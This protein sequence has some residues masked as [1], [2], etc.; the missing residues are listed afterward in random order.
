MDKMKF[1]LNKELTYPAEKFRRNDIE[2]PKN[3]IT[4]K[5]TMKFQKTMKVQNTIKQR[6]EVLSMNSKSRTHVKKVSSKSS[7]KKPLTKSKESSLKPPPKKLVFEDTPK[8]FK[9]NL[10]GQL[11][12]VNAQIEKMN[13]SVE[14]PQKQ[15]FLRDFDKEI[16]NERDERIRRS[17]QE[18]KQLNENILGHNIKIVENSLVDDSDILPNHRKGIPSAMRISS[19]M[20]KKDNLRKLTKK[21]ITAR[22]P[23]EILKHTFEQN[24]LK[25]EAQ[26]HTLD[27]QVSYIK[28]V[29]DQNELPLPVFEKLRDHCLKLHGY[30]INSHHMDSLC[31]EIIELEGEVQSII[32]DDIKISQNT[33]IK[34]C[35]TIS[36]NPHITSVIFRNIRSCKISR[37]CIEYLSKVIHPESHQ[38]GKFHR[39]TNLEIHNCLMKPE[40]VEKLTQ[41]LPNNKNLHKLVLTYLPLT[42]GS[43]NNLIQFFSN[44]YNLEDINLSWC[45]IFP[46]SLA[47]V[48]KSLQKIKNLRYLSLNGLNLDIKDYNLVFIESLSHLIVYVFLPIEYIPVSPCCEPYQHK[49][50]FSACSDS[51]HSFF[52]EADFDSYDLEDHCY[53]LPGA[54]PK[55]LEFRL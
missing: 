14:I 19:E 44:N 47:L 45:K 37:K 5:R 42:E 49:S 48:V 39:L 33:L 26:L 12:I 17:N 29:R 6:S 54:V 10:K 53:V 27:N 55:D 30:S 1:R 40:V 16:H 32:L 8:K 7:L 35:K 3:K 25:N 23:G 21:I 34:M 50:C 31:K 24:F 46:K 22:D 38:A 51:Q 2:V 20:Q 36:S 28:M 18:F 15:K 11:K 43:A 41:I 13:N 4:L 9:E 52:K